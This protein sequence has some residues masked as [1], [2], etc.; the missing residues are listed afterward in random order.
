[1]RIELGVATVLS[2]CTLTIAQPAIAPASGPCAPN[3]PW[4]ASHARVD[5]WT[6]FRPSPDSRVVFVSSSAGNDANSG[7]SELAPKRSIA[8]GYALLRDGFPDWL[9]LKSGDAWNESFPSWSKGGRSETEMMRIGSYGNGPRP[10]IRSGSSNGFYAAAYPVPKA[11][12]A[13]TDM[14]FIPHTYSGDEPYPPGGIVILNYWSDILIENCKVERYFV[15]IT[16]EGIANQGIPNRTFIRRSVVADAFRVGTAEAAQGLFFAARD[17]VLEENLFDHNGWRQDVVG[18]VPTIF[19]HN[20]YVHDSSTGLV[21]TRGNI[22]ARASQNGISQRCSGLI[23]GNLLLQNP[24][25]IPAA[26]DALTVRFNTCLDS[27]DAGLAIT[28]NGGGNVNV[29]ENIIAHGVYGGAKGLH[30]VGAYDRL[31]VR[32]NVV[33]DWS[34]DASPLAIAAQYEG[35]EQG[36]IEFTTNDLQQVRAGYLISDYPRSAGFVR[37]RGNRYF[38]TNPPPHQMDINMTYP[39]WVLRSGETS[40]SFTRASFPAPERDITSYAASVGLQPSLEA[41]L[42]AARNQARH[43]WNPALTAD[44]ANAYIRAGFGR[45][46]ASCCPADING[47]GLLNAADAIEFATAFYAGNPIA[48]LDQD[49]ALTISDFVRFQLGFSQGCN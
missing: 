42:A 30:F 9:L 15:N 40:S 43:N 41:F 31:A 49:H 38:T 46:P 36:V 33:Y 11:H 7:L 5:G 27:R 29:Y 14:H 13:L 17:L 21:V 26:G 37:Y 18:A 2:A 25:H 23:E 20:V 6:V 45:P 12:L 47:D 34:R 1:M 44:A 3:P 35:A 22:V 16:V 32:R 39:A 28:L 24:V 48:D 19:R 8:A 10:L 4:T